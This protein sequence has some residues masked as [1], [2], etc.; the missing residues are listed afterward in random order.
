SHRNLTAIR[1]ILDGAPLS[2][3]ARSLSRRAFELL[4]EA[5]GRVHGIAPDQVHFHEVGAV[6]AIVDIVGC[7]V[8][9]D[10]LGL[11]RWYASPVNVGSGFAD[12]AHGR[13]P[14][15]A[16][17]TAALLQQA[18]VYSAGPAMELTTPTGAA[19]LRALGCRFEAPGTLR[20]SAIGYGAGGRNPARFPNVLRLTVGEAA[21]FSAAEGSR[22]LGDEKVTVIECAV[23]DLSPQ[24]LAYTAQLAMERGAL[25]VMTSPVTMKKGRLGTLL[26]VLSRPADAS[27]LEELLFRE[28]STLGMRVREESRLVLAR[29][30]VLVRTEFGEIRMKIGSWRG[31]EMNAAPEFEDCRRAAEAGDAPLKAVMQAAMAEWRRGLPSRLQGGAAKGGVASGGEE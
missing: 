5:E 13:F 11:N 17:A 26:T 3:R 27:G 31:E 23:D 1:A 6:D 8:A 9:V 29:E 24:V 30:T 7:A 25:D 21:P 28:T 20:S 19:L 12:C 16:P 22:G 15:P 18:P 10:L 4:A 14:V 2:Q